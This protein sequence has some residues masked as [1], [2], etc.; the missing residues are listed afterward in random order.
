MNFVSNFHTVFLIDL[1]CCLNPHITNGKEPWGNRPYGSLASHNN[2]ELTY[3][4]DI[5]SW[6][7]NVLR[8]LNLLPYGPDQEAK[9]IIKPVKKEICD[10]GSIN[11]VKLPGTLPNIIQII[12]NLKLGTKPDYENILKLLDL[13]FDEKDIFLQLDWNQ[14]FRYHGPRYAVVPH[15]LPCYYNKFCFNGIDTICLNYCNA[16]FS[17]RKKYEGKY[18]NL[19]VFMCSKPSCLGRLVVAAYEIEKLHNFEIANVVGKEEDHR[20]GKELDAINFFYNRTK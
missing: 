19:A 17:R 12:Y 16:T 1:G 6:F 2:Q 13:V 18:E 11:G 9:E 8:W 20:C 10:N 15:Q 7:Y 4:D 3:K 14:G 5:E